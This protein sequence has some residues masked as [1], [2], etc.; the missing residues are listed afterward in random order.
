M[1]F[2]RSENS[3]LRNYLILIFE[4]ST[5]VFWGNCSYKYVEWMNQTLS[6]RFFVFKK[7]KIAFEICCE[8]TTIFFFII[9][10]FNILWVVNVKVGNVLLKTIFLY[11]LQG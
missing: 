2:R 4:N 7:P 11:T 6:Y 3:K 5:L 10:F 8:S 9:Y 1:N